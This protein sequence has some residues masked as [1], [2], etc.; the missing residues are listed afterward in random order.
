MARKR[1]QRK[2]AALAAPQDRH[3]LHIILLGIVAV[4]AIVG[5]VLMFNARMTGKSIAGIINPTIYGKEDNCY[6]VQPFC[7]NGRRTPV[8]QFLGADGMLHVQCGCPNQDPPVPPV[9]IRV[10]VK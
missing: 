7:A 9:E 5:L 6:N 3:D 4:L 2:R 1:V 8:S 10:D